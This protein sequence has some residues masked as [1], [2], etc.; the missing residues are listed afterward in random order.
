M[1][2][3]SVRDAAKILDVSPQF[4]RVGLQR[5]KLKIGTAIFMKRRWVYHIS[6]K[7]LADY[8]GNDDFMKGDDGFEN[9][10]TSASRKQE[11]HA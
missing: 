4:V 1:K 10:G 6:P 2:K 3:V 8:I 5:E 9:N 7:L 11:S